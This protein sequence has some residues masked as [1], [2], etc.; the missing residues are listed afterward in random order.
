MLRVIFDKITFIY[1]RQPERWT[2]RRRFLT[3]N[4]S[5]YYSPRNDAKAARR[6]LG[7]PTTLMMTSS[8]PKKG[9]KRGP[10]EEEDDCEEDSDSEAKRPR[11]KAKVLGSLRTFVLRNFWI[12]FVFSPSL[13]RHLAVRPAAVGKFRSTSY[14][15]NLQMSTSAP[16]KDNTWP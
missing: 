2:F 15:R 9:R 7:K 12:N 8:S 1:I 11:S 16:L 6:R 5:R 13:S 14:L 4:L 3:M 10:R